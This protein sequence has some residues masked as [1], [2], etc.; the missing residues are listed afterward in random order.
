MF[1]PHQYGTPKRGAERLIL[2]N[3]GFVFR[4][5]GF[6]RRTPRLRYPMGEFRRYVGN[7]TRR[8]YKRR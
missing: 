3:N 8:T 6:A 7:L 4:D 1:E 5:R 2:A